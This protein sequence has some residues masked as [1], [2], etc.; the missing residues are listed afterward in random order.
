MVVGWWVGVGVG[1]GKGGG[2][3]ADPSFQTSWHAALN[4]P[5]KILQIKIKQ[6]FII[7]R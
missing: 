3:E 5:V 6:K 1:W 4:K 2:G 7:D